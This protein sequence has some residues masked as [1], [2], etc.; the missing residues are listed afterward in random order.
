MEE[1]ASSMGGEFPSVS[2]LPGE[3]TSSST[4]SSD[5]PVLNTVR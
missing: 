1:T 3:I 5:H 2:V 4:E